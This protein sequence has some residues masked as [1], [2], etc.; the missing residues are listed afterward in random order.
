MKL[1]IDLKRDSM[2]LMGTSIVNN[3]AAFLLFMI[4]A[5]YLSVDAIGKINFFMSILVLF[6]VLG[7]GG[8]LQYLPALA[9]KRK[10][11]NESPPLPYVGWAMIWVSLASIISLL[12]Y[13]VGFFDKFEI[14]LGR[15]MLCLPIYIF[16][17]SFVAVIIALLIGYKLLKTVMWVSIF[18][19]SSRCFVIFLLFQ[20]D[21]LSWKWVIQSFLMVYIFF[22]IVLFLFC[23]IWIKRYKSPSQISWK[24][25]SEYKHA[26]AFLL[27]SS[28]HMFL[29]KWIILL[30][31]IFFTSYQTGLFSIAIL[32]MSFF[33]LI[34]TPLQTAYLG[35]DQ[36]SPNNIFKNE[37]IEII[38]KLI[39]LI[40]IMTNYQFEKEG[41]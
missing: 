21:N 9:R 3:G 23:I 32:W 10:L 2:I 37:L 25:G 18:I 34:L 36:S 1:N 27:P 26:A 39:F 40:I 6:T 7:S 14:L 12:M 20:T 31:G 8:L 29:P 35:Y 5:K 33:P 28:S 15:I 16:F 17:S 41:K 30:C 24:F 22:A 19:E 11:L 4:I 38:K 13:A